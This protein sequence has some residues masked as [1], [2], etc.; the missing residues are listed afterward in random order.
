MRFS[1]RKTVL[2]ATP[3]LVALATPTFGA[4]LNSKRDSTCVS[5]GDGKLSLDSSNY[6][7]SYGVNERTFF[8]TTSNINNASVFQ[9]QNCSTFSGSYTPLYQ[10]AYMVSIPH[11]SSATR[12]HD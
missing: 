9:A 5:L 11:I 6:L 1:T 10:I 4:A 2:Q 7:T 12:H 3:L 8:T